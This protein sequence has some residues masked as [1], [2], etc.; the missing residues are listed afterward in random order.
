MS[1]KSIFL[2]NVSKY[3]KLYNNPKD[4]L[5]EALHPF[6]KK[7]HKKFYALKKINLQVKK[8][9]ILGIIG[10][11]GS[12][13]STL[14]KLIS[15]VIQPG[16]GK[17]VVNGAISALL[18]LGT[19]LNPEFNGIQNIYFSGTMMGFSRE[20]MKN[21]IDDIV[22]F[23]DIGDFIHQPL[24][25]YS[26]GMKARLGFALA[27]NM[28]PRILILDEVLSV[29][30]ELF[31]RKCYVKME[32]FFESGCTVLYVSHSMN[33]INEIC[34][35]AILME[36]GELLL[37]GPAK[38]VTTYYQKLLYAAEAN[39]KEVREDIINL[40]KDESKK[41]EFVENLEK[42]ELP[43]PVKEKEDIQIDEKKPEPAQKPLYLP[44]FKPKSTIE[45]KNY[46]VDIYD[47]HIKTM[48]GEKVNALVMDEE[49][50]YSYKV[51]FNINAG[52]VVFGSR[53]KTKKGLLISGLNSKDSQKK[54]YDVSKRDE[55]LVEYR[56]KCNLLPGT[57]FITS[58]VASVMDEEP[59]FL[60]RVVDALVFKVQENPSNVYRG[61]IHLY[62]KL[63][64]EKIN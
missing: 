26:S 54:A 15:G 61:I 44:D 2:E 33:T 48:D 3:Y 31:K 59:V 17:V 55:Y 30:D 16:S 58:G 43:P 13:K 37:E 35:R 51:K 36:N 12:G 4:R 21:K 29:G 57:Y 8:G 19:G 56:F 5:K 20:E 45:Y 10:R 53:F 39:Q 41:K 27:I 34:S 60:N 7:Y 9:E 11:N 40:N 49:Y 64:V 6:G 24:L 1:D 63:T 38:L 42:Q 14:L 25:T 23:A 47:F 50:I 22:S 18:E 32:E 52:N 28:E 46:D 62:Q